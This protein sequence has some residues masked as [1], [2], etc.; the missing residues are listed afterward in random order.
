MR[1]AVAF[2]DGAIAPKFGHTKAFKVYQVDDAGKIQWGR[3]IRVANTD[4]EREEKANFLRGAGV[5]KLICGGI[6]KAGQKAVAN[7][8]IE[9]FGGVAGDA[10]QALDAL[11]AGTLVY[12]TDPD[13][14]KCEDEDKDDAEK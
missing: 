4:E 10:D 6:C 3:E 14:L 12:E 9:L 2:E 8:G 11:L 13:K 7:A 5:S 1:I